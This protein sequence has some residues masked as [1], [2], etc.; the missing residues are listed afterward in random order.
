MQNEDY[1]DN[2]CFICKCKTISYVWITSVDKNNKKTKAP[3]G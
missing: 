1:S 2:F 3:C